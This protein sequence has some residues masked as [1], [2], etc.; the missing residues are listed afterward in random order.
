MDIKTFGAMNAYQKNADAVSDS[1]GRSLDK[2]LNLPEQAAERA[3]ERVASN[4][5]AIKFE[6]QASI[7]A[8]LFGTEQVATQSSLQISLQSAI[9]EVN[10]QLRIDLGLD[11]SAAD[12][13]SNEALAEQGGMDYWTPENTAQRI[14]QGTTAFLSGFQNAHP[15]L[16]GEELINRFI[17]VIGQGISDG[18]SQ[19]KGFLGDLS[20]LS[21][22][23]EGNIN[24]TYDF[25]QQGLE[26]FKK[27]FLGMSD[28]NS[29]SGISAS[30]QSDLN[31]ELEQN[32]EGNA[33]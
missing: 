2:I 14:V 6:Q 5:A 8:N 20:V 10:K 11:A 4:P 30:A 27:D 31:V 3:K 7:V 33:E 28:S 24:Q 22:E 23:I 13:V 25:V 26:N 17:E 16:Q 12:P 21:E 32:S 15:E 1:R 18:F 19:A 29:E 9:E